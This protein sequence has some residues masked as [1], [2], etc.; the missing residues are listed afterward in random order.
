MLWSHLVADRRPLAGGDTP[1]DV[2][3]RTVRS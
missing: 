1:A 2:A 3:T